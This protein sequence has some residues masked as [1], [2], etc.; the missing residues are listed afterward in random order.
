MSEVFIEDHN[1][2]LK[3]LGEKE[4]KVERQET[5]LKSLIKENKEEIS[6]SSTATTYGTPKPKKYSSTIKNLSIIKS[7]G[8][9]FK[10]SLTPKARFKKFLNKLN[11]YLSN[12]KPEESKDLISA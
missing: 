6:N 1:E 11:S 8:Y 2:R 3:K 10:I 7:E 9:N 5:I 4:E 12:I